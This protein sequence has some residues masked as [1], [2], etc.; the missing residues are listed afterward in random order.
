MSGFEELK[1]GDRVIAY[2]PR[3]W[4]K[5]KKDVDNNEDCWLPAKVMCVYRNH[6]DLVV[7]LLFDHDSEISHGHFIDG[8]CSGIR[9]ILKVYGR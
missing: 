6:G 4:N 7:D 2:D 8:G 5:R 1:Y 3:I 9:E